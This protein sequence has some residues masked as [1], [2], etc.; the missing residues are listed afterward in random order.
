M[1][2]IKFYN[3]IDFK[4]TFILVSLLILSST[5]GSTLSFIGGKKIVKEKIKNHLESVVILKENQV[6]DWLEEKIHE[7]EIF[8][9]DNLVIGSVKELFSTRS[10]RD[11]KKIHKDLCKFLEL[12]NK[13]HPD[14]LEI[15]ILDLDGV[16]RISTDQNQ[17]GKIKADKDYFLKGKEKTFIQNIFYDVGLQKLTIVISSPIKYQTKTLAVLAIR[18]NLNKLSEIMLERSGL[19][20]TGETYL[21][22]QSNYAVTDL[23]YSEKGFKETIYTEQVKDCLKGNSSHKEGVRNYKGERVIAAYTWIPKNELCLIAE[24]SEKEAFAPVFKLRNVTILI[25][26]LLVLILTILGYWFSKTIT[27]PLYQLHKGTEIIAKGNLDYRIGLKSKD[28]IGQLAKAFDLMT[29][30][31]KKSRDKLEQ[32][33]KKLEEKV[34][35]RTRELEE[36]KKQLEKKVRDLEKFTRLATGRELKMIELKKRIKELEDEIKYLRSKKYGSNKFS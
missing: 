10:K 12:R 25:N 23:K 35:D 21:I 13:K 20:D 8:A 24:I 27:G 11:F 4:L 19:G 16:I 7:I 14:F 9:Q 30:E 17:E 22:N 3:R 5:I 18:L 34:K 32:Y 29:E 28:E 26:I 1:E 36:A 6:R 33:S 15:F 31:L 2:K